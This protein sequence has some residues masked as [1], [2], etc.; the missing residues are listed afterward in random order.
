[1]SALRELLT[2]VVERKASDLHLKPGS[3]PSLRVDA[4]LVSLERDPFSPEDMAHITETLIPPHMAEMFQETREADFSLFEEGIGRFRINVFHSGGQCHIA[5]RHVKS[6]VPSFEELH[7][8]DIIKQIALAPRGIVIVS[9]TTGCGKSTT[10]AAIIEHINRNLRRRILTVE[11]PVEYVFRDRMSI[12]SQR[13][14]GL[15][16]LSFP[17]P[18]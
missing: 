13:E 18:L 1:M 5:V 8:L 16:T 14:V 4:E 10:L 6:E 7:L 17:A 2:C 3:P 15:D 11:D 9:G 12:I